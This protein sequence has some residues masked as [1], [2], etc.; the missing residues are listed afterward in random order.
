MRIPE[1]KSTS[2]SEPEWK[3]NYLIRFQPRSVSSIKHLLYEF[4]SLTDYKECVSCHGVKV[5]A[6]DYHEGSRKNSKSDASITFHRD[7]DEGSMVISVIV[8]LSELPS[9]IAIARTRDFSLDLSDAVLF[10]WTEKLLK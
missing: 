10:H 2:E 1:K 9:S 4:L 6:N 8:S 7:G 3:G 5:F